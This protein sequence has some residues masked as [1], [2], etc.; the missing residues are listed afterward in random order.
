MS[1]LLEHIH[2]NCRTLEKINFGEHRSLDLGLVNQSIL[3][4][5]VS[6]L[7]HINL[8]STLWDASPIE[9]ILLRINLE[10]IQTIDLS[11]VNLCEV[12]KEVLTSLARHAADLSLKCTH[13][14]TEQLEAI[15]QSYL[16][17][18]GLQKLNIE[19]LGFDGESLGHL[20]LVKRVKEKLSYNFMY[21]GRMAMLLVM[22]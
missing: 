8:S 19:G 6:N 2:N 12:N 13:L 1:M 16:E 11:H 3:G 17:N 18:D 5:I 22:M 4:D 10:K 21:D 9:S 7:S 15:L 14:T 20:D